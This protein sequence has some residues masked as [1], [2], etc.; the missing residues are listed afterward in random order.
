M[1]SP[2]SG[3]VLGL[4]LLGATPL[5]AQVG[6]APTSS[7]YRDIFHGKSITAVVG[8]IGGDGGRIGVGPHNGRSYG[9]RFDVRI[10]AP[11]HFAATVA[12]ADVERFVVSADDSVATRKKGPVDQ[13]LTMFEAAMQLNI[14]GKKSWHRLAPFIGMSVGYVDGG[15][16]PAGA[17]ADSSGYNFGGKF[18]LAPAIGARVFLGNNLHLRFEARQLFW[19]LSYPVS[20]TAEPDAQPSTDPDNPNAVLP[21]GK[22]DEWSGGREL[23]V[24]LGFAF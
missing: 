3:A 22:R 4:A 21:N 2:F 9:L 11:V 7:P 17:P 8:D 18:Y 12:K 16:L 15:G 1:R 20:Y 6:H 13:G 24:G 23:R 19:K 14:T 10:G 5:A